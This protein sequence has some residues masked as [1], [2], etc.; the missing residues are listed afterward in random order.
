MIK[1]ALALAVCTTLVGCGAEKSA[2]TAQVEA[3]AEQTVT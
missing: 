3:K 1:K 2:Y